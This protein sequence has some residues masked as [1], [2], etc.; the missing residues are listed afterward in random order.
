MLNELL[1]DVVRHVLPQPRKHS[2]KLYSMRMKGDHHIETDKLEEGEGKR[3]D[4]MP[5]LRRRGI[6]RLLCQSWTAWKAAPSCSA[7]LFTGNMFHSRSQTVSDVFIWLWRPCSCLTPVGR[8]FTE[9]KEVSNTASAS[10][11]AT[12]SFSVTPSSYR[13]IIMSCFDSGAFNCVS[14]F[15]P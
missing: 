13:G 4:P 5:D 6:Q 12:F 15:G 14:L 10:N 9:D 8:E 2:S 3:L 7:L 1:I 11:A